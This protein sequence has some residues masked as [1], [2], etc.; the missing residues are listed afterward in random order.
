M[1]AE[2]IQ[3][4]YGD[5]GGRTKEEIAGYL[6]ACVTEFD[7]YLTG[8]VWGFKLLRFTEDGDEEGEEVDSCWGHICDPDP[9][10]N[11][12]EP[13]HEDLGEGKWIQI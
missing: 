13:S 1:T 4:E 11:H 8:N 7:N 3:H 9:N 10:A 5:H 12:M 6:K 2:E